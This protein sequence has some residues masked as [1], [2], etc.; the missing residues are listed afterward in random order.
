MIINIAPATIKDIFFNKLFSSDSIP[1]NV[2]PN[3]I[4]E[5]QAIVAWEELAFWILAT[6]FNGKPVL[7]AVWTCNWVNIAFD[8][9]LLPVRKPP[10]PP[11]K[12]D[13]YINIVPNINPAALAITTVILDAVI[14][15]EIATNAVV[16]ITKGTHCF[17][18][19]LIEIH[20][21]LLEIL[22]MNIVYKHVIKSQNPG[23]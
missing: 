22:K 11:I 14:S 1:H 19:V 8:P 21:I 3:A 16:E 9:V 17:I 7:V 10:I 5:G 6:K 23:E 20:T 12:G 18:V 2:A 4:L 13:I 15:W